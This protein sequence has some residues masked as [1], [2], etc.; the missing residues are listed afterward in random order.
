MKRKNPMAEPD[1]MASARCTARSKQR[2]TQCKQP[3]IPGGKVC[4]FHG[5]SAPQVIRSARERIAAAA[6]PAIDVLLK[7]LKSRNE[8]LAANVA[9][10]I[11]DRAGHGAKHKHDV[12]SDGQSL[13]IGVIT[14]VP[15]PR[16]GR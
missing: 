15:E 16:R 3:A 2:G 13:Q 11:L 4:R 1:P 12:T 10:D 8:R 9:Q 7:A 6:D 14:S 5:G